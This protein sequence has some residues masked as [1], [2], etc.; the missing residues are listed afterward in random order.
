[1]MGNYAMEKMNLQWVE[2]PMQF[3]KKKNSFCISSKNLNDESKI[4]HRYP[5]PAP[6]IQVS[7]VSDQ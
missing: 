1:M 3:A 7:R 6:I 4:G 2:P 5:G